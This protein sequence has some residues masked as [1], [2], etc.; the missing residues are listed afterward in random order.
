MTERE[1]RWL[2]RSDLLE[3]L[4]MLNKENEQLKAQLEQAEEQ[5]RE[6]SITIDQ[7]GSIAEAALKLSGVFEAAQKACDEYITNVKRAH[8]GAEELERQSRERSEMIL[9]DAEKKAGDIVKSA[10][11]EA[12]RMLAEA[13]ARSTNMMEDARKQSEGYWGQVSGK[14]DEFYASCAGLR[15]LLGSLPAAQQKGDEA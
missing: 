1:I 13:A 9:A 6:R 4:L 5:K 2:S 10:E 14:I 8:A 3:M 7:S 15:E 11:N 12:A